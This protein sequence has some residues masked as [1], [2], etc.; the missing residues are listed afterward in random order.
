MCPNFGD[1]NTILH[2]IKLKNGNAILQYTA[3]NE[4]RRIPNFEEFSK[5]SDWKLVKL[6]GHTVILPD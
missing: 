6:C 3:D 2:P 1:S 4:F 5:Q